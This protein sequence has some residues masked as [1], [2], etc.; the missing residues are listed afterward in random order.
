MLPVTRGF[1]LPSRIQAFRLRGTR[2]DDRKPNDPG[3]LVKVE[4]LFR[5]NRR[6]A[7]ES[8]FAEGMY[9]NV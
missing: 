7:K 8:V 3:A 4:R 5:T 6:D 9:I 2:E 1:R